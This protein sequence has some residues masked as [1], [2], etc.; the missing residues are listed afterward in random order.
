MSVNSRQL[1]PKGYWQD[2]QN[3][4]R[5]IRQYNIRCGT[6]EE[7]PREKELKANGFGS[8]ATAIYQYH[9]GFQRVATRLRL[10][11]RRRPNDIF[12]KFEA[13]EKEF[14]DWVSKNGKPGE[15]P[16]AY[17]LRE[18]GR[19]DLLA[20][21]TGRFGGFYEVAKRMNLSVRVKPDGYWLD[22]E[23][24]KKELSD[25]ITEFGT[26]GKLPSPQELNN[27]GYSSLNRAIWKHGN[28]FEMAHRLELAPNRKPKGFW[29]TAGVL[30]REIL[31]FV[32]NFGTPGQMPIDEELRSHGRHDLSV[33][34]ARSTFGTRELADILGLK[35]RASLPDHHWDDVRVIDEEVMQFVEQKRLG[36]SMPTLEQ[37]R[38]AGRHDLIN[39]IGRKGGGSHDTA[40]R[41]NLQVAEK[42]KGFWKD[43]INVS[44]A[45]KEFCEK[46]GHPRVMPDNM[47]LVSWGESSLAFAIGK[48]G[49]FPAVAR[50]LRFRSPAV[51][52]APRSKDEIFLAWELSVFLPVDFGSHKVTVGNKVY[53]VDI[54]ISSENMIVEYD[55][56]HWH[57]GN[58]DKDKKKTR[59]LEAEG[60]TV[61]RAREHPLERL[62]DNDVVVPSAKYK[63]T[64]DCVLRK[65]ESILNRRFFGLDAYEQQ[66]DLVKQFEAEA[67]I[68]RILREKMGLSPLP[69]VY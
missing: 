41:N 24:V 19:H 2:F 64:A 45:I 23:N 10:R 32:E 18:A 51:V 38:D 28:Y 20:A 13:L 25:W 55:G 67:E 26:E 60:W 33:A 5:E 39:A 59:R 9:G 1:K 7:M 53:D 58:E 11:T 46:R 65:L 30:E 6:L 35:S 54:I 52:L 36:N 42:P 66:K 61:V 57:S 15:M 12:A 62:N 29:S 44:A 68:T 27:S 37:L 14:L 43:F 69:S 3:V 16:T 8:L 40:T 34:I 47:E 50:R 63:T 21:I 4:E 56:H 22:L 31:D 48:H 17:E 49:G